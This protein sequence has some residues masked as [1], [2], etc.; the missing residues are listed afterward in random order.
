MPCP[1][2]AG[3]TAG[4]ARV[5]ALVRQLAVVTSFVA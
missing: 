1:A 4:G 5:S 3:G 2:G